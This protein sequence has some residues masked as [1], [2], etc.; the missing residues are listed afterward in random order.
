MR[1]T[2]AVFVLLASPFIVNAFPYL[3][4]NNVLPNEVLKGAPLTPT[5][6]IR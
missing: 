5:N 6:C 3:W 1:A 4:A 2:L